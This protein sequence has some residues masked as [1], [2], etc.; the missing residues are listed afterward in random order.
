MRTPKSIPDGPKLSKLKSKAASKPYAGAV[1]TPKSQKGL[2]DYYGTGVR[3]KIGRM[4]SGIGMVD[5]NPKKLNT[6]PRSLA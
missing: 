3:A 4:R 6:P 2:G 1:H 5:L